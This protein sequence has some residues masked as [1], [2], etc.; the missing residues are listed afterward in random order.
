MRNLVEQWSND[1]DQFGLSRP[2]SVVS[3]RLQQGKQRSIGGSS[4]NVTAESGHRTTAVHKDTAVRATA[5]HPDTGKC[6]L[7]IVMLVL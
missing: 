7:K 1:I 5:L 6:T 4:D 2:R 3:E